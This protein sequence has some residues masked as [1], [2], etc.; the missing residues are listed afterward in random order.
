MRELGISVYPGHSEVE[1]NKEY[2]KLAAKHGFT[3]IF[4]CL[5]SVD[6]NEKK[7]IEEFKETI[8][9]ANSLGFKVIADVNPK[10]FDKL[11]ISHKNLKFFKELEVYGVRLDVGFSGNEEALMTF[12]EYNLKIELN[13]S[14]NTNYISTIMD[15]KPNKYNLLGC[16][17]F[18]PHIYTGLSREHFRACNEKFTKYGLKTSA[19]VNSKNASFGPWPVNDGICTLE[20]HRTLPIDIAAKDL[21]REGIDCVIVANYYASEEELKKLGSLRK[22]LLELEIT[23][24]DN[25]PE[26]EKDIVVNTLHFNRGDLGEHYIRSSQTRTKY[27][28]HHFELFNPVDIKKGDI[29]IDTSLYGTYAGELQIARKSMKNTGKTNVIG[30]IREEELYLL[31]LIVPWEKFILKEKK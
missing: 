23:L 14:N 11:G 30:K 15:Y 1:K 26:V 24:V 3:R 22:D 20:E 31:D 12:N 21:F 18:Y 4:T 10:I 8:N 9:Y 27:E 25:I 29:I 19:F 16:H 17:N 5:L 13:M 7:I 6:G 28:G 2:I